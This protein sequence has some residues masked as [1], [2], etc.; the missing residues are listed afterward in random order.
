MCVSFL[1][2]AR[3]V[4]DKSCREHQNTHFVFSKSPP[5]T[6][7]AYEKMWKNIIQPDKPHMTIWRMRIACWVPK[8]TSTH[9]QVVYYS[10]LY[11]CNNGCTNAPRCCVIRTLPVLL[12]IISYIKSAI[13]AVVRTT[14]H[15]TQGNFV[16]R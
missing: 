6:R 7:A 16:W 9:T 15:R 11:H 8:A 14:R 5:E 13:M 2:R 3:N 10:L 4:S 1:L 12:T